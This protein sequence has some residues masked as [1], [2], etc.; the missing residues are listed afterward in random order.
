MADREQRGREIAHR[1]WEDEGRP[2]GEHQRHWA[3]A[4][5]M[6]AQADHASAD[7]AQPAAAK[8]A[9]TR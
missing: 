2:S 6:V 1:L 9:G 5:H 3:T 8:R 7:A 4:E